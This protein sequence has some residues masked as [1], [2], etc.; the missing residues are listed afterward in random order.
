MQLGNEKKYDAGLDD[1][2]ER[3]NPKW[4]CDKCISSININESYQ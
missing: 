2:L 3:I 4:F 1:V